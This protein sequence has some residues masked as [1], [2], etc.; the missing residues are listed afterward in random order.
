[1]NGIHDMGGMH[2]FGRIPIEEDEPVFH[3]EWEARVLAVTLAVGAWKRWNLDATR[4]AREAIPPAAYLQMSYYE[5]WLS[6]LTRQMLDAGLVT[7]DE[8]R[9]GRPGGAGAG[10]DAAAPPD[11]ET[12]RA[13]LRRGGSTLRTIQAEPRFAAGDG[14]RT[15]N[16][17]PAGHTRLPRYARGRNGVV[18]CHH[19]AHVLPDSNAHFRG[20]CP[21]HLYAVR[22]TAREL[23]GPDASAVDSVT[24]DL[25]ESYLDAV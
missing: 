16:R 6:A 17:H 14:V 4:C 11:A 12:A 8:L 1:M 2:G 7:E 20:E 10:H 23:W 3:A 9:T 5:R 22:F 21:Q 18:V 24:L 13:M 15:V 25:W 19:G